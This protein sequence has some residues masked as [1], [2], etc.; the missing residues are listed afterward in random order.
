MLASTTNFNVVLSEM[1]VDRDT[2]KLY[3]PILGTELARSGMTD[4]NELEDFLGQVAHESG[5]FKRTVENLNYDAKGLLKTWPNRFTHATANGYSRLPEKIANHV[6]ANRL[7]NGSEESGDGWKYRGRGLIQ[8]TGKANYANV[9]KILNNPDLLDFPELLAGPSQAVQSAIAFWQAKGL[10]DE[11]L[12]DDVLSVTKQIN[13]GTHGLEER[14]R[15]T[16]LAR[17]ALKELR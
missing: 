2:A 7:G 16:L 3:G 1:G 8:V 14:K 13:G 15:L 12:A 10:K 5:M 6:Y 17:K 4:P 11:A 9:G